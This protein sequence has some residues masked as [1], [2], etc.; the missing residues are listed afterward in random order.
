[1][2]ALAEARYRGK[3]KKGRSNLCAALFRPFRKIGPF[4]FSSR[5]F[6]F[7][8]VH[9]P[10]E[11]FQFAWRKLGLDY[12]MPSRGIDPFP[13]V[14][15]QQDFD[16]EPFFQHRN[17][18]KWSF[19]D[20]PRIPRVQYEDEFLELLDELKAKWAPA[21]QA[22]RSPEDL[23]AITAMDSQRFECHRVGYNYRS[24][25]FRGDGTFA[26][27]GVGCECY[28]TIREGQLLI[29]G[30][31]GRLTM[32][33]VAESNQPARWIT[34]ASLLPEANRL[35]AIHMLGGAGSAVRNDRPYDLPWEP[36]RS[37]S[38]SPQR[39]QAVCPTGCHESAAARTSSN[40]A[41]KRRPAS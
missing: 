11:V 3:G 37:P 21:A 17:L 1:V 8:H 19:Y 34:A 39:W 5:R 41:A 15:A 10:K 13:G 40:H 29:A 24:M 31:N 18:R 9:R 2:S 12:A 23:G 35:L 38:N 16:G 7:P 27:G 22:L 26:A 32:D 6:Y 14:M 30:D 28:W 25:V 4:L 36:C 20:N 33:Y